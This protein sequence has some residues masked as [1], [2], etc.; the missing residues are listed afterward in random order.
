MVVRYLG[1]IVVYVGRYSQSSDYVSGLKV[2]CYESKR[3]F[4]KCANSSNVPVDNLWITLVDS[5]PFTLIKALNSHV[6]ADA[7][8]L[9]VSSIVTDAS[10]PRMSSRTSVTLETHDKST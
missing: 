1:L 9:E 7:W 8:D 5:C 10:L 4:I 2:H 6:D 3:K